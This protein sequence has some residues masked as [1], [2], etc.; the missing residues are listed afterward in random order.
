[1]RIE[2]N[3]HARLAT[4]DDLNKIADLW[5]KDIRIYHSKD[6]NYYDLRLLN[7]DNYIADLKVGIEDSFVFV[8]IVDSIIQGYATIDYVGDGINN[9]NEIRFMMIG[10]FVVSQSYKSMN[11]GKILM[12]VLKDRAKKEGCQRIDLNIH[13]DDERAGKFFADSGFHT[14]FNTVALEIE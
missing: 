7:K 1:M 5:E 9:Y 4:G 8:L 2:P 3:P 11:N 13:V 10:D 14:R 12:K 6:N